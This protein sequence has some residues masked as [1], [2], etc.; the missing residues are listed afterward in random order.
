MSAISH[1]NAGEPVASIDGK[2]GKLSIGQTDK[3]GRDFRGKGRL[4]YVGQRYLQFAETGE[5]FLKCGADAPE[6]FLA[7]QDFDNTPD[8]GGRLKSWNAHVRDWK[9]GDPTWRDGKGKG[10]IG[11]LNYLA[12]EGMNAFS[13][14]PFTIYGGDKNVFPY[15]TERG[16]FTRFDCSKLA[17]WRTLFLSTETDWASTSTSRPWKLKTSWCWTVATSAWN[18]GCITAN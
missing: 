5:W 4:E 11:A 2:S 1:P 15:L 9:P 13:F 8:N 14:M 18:A 17:Q 7:Y 6:N 12:S 16:P 3:T 10:I